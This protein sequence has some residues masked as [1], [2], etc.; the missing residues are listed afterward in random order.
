VASAVLLA[1]ASGAGSTASTG[2]QAAPD[3]RPAHATSAG[4]LGAT[5]AISGASSTNAISAASATGAISAASAT[6]ATEPPKTGEHLAQVGWASSKWGDPA[7]DAKAKVEGKNSPGQDA[8]SLATVATA[9]GARDLWKKN[10]ADGRAI[11][12]Q[13][14][15]VALIDTGIDTSVPGLNGPGKVI[16]GPDLSFEANSADLR[17]RDT[18]G[19][20]THM[21]SIIA[22]RDAVP[23]KAQTGCPEP[24]D[25]SVQLGIA[26]DA[27]LLA[28]KVGASDGSA[29][30]SQVIAGLDWV[31]QHRNDNGM[32]VRVINLSYG[33]LSAQPY[34]LDPLAAA[35]ENAWKHG[36]VVVVSGGNEGPTAGRLTDPAIDPYVIAVGASDPLA[37]AANWSQPTVASFSS[38]GSVDRHVDLVAPGASIA[39]LR[40]TGSYIDVHHPEGL[41]SGDTTGRLFRGSGTSQAA[42]VTS[43]AAALLL[44]AYPDLTPDQV[45]ATIVNTAR[46]IGGTEIDRGAGQ[47]DLSGALIEAKKLAK[48]DD[49][50]KD[51]SAQTFPEATGAGSLEAARGGGNMIDPETG[52]VLRGEFDVQNNA[53]DGSAWRAASVSGTTWVGGEWNG[54]RW[55]GDAWS[56]AVWMNAGWDG[57]R[58]TGARWSDVSWTGAVWAGAR[59]T[60]AGWTGQ[61]WQ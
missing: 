38:R 14:V 45:K 4:A 13:G 29:D 25:A 60:G 23:V 20:G 49:K 59:W 3:V 52:A 8:G 6:G 1:A 30:V 27:R 11:T 54:A 61:G 47:L 58:W 41:V 34:Q 19:H 10:D 2:Y 48:S 39:G 7:T 21:G 43:G 37:E 24:A 31:V 42:A 44:Q 56:G 18:F 9:I 51:S 53:W 16:K 32:Q 50:G 15:T 57:D 46:T 40:A 17:G 12:G 35:A 5:G 33:T 55:S 26:P 22:A 28:V 36:I